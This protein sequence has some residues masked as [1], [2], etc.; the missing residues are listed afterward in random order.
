M[1]N[2]DNTENLITSERL[3]TIIGKTIKSYYFTIDGD[4]LVSFTDNSVFKLT[5]KHDPMGEFIE[6][7]KTCSA[8]DFVVANL[9]L[10]I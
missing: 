7:A 5:V 2:Y 8:Y 4:F 1:L 3:P 10:L 9:Q 6:V